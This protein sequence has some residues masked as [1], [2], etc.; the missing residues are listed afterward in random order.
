MTGLHVFQSLILTTGL[1]AAIYFLGAAVAHELR[2][3]R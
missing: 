2:K 3:D 1:I